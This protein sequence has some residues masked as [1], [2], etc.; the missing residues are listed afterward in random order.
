MLK[1]N[2]AQM[3]EINPAGCV[4]ASRH[5]APLPIK[6]YTINLLNTFFCSSDMIIAPKF[7]HDGISIRKLMKHDNQQVH[8]NV[9]Q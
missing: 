5:I 6:L 7:I 8:E 3:L 4:G 9:I 1:I 2:K